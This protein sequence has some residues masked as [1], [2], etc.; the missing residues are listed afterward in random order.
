MS[1]DHGH[2]EGGGVY[3]NLPSDTPNRT[4]VV[5]ART[6]VL[7]RK[8]MIALCDEAIQ[9]GERGSS[10]LRTKQELRGIHKDLFPLRDF[11][12]VIELS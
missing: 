3:R 12:Y 8:D 2:G 10:L 11:Y 1:G 7:F 6:V 9:K 5:C 4:P